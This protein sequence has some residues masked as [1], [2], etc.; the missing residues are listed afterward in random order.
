MIKAIG[1]LFL[2]LGRYVVEQ[3]RAGTQQV[4]DLLLRSGRRRWR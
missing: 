3:V 2:N 1:N 4:V